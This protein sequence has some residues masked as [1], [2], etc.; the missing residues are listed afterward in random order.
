MHNYQPGS[1]PGIGHDN[2]PGNTTV[3]SALAGIVGG[4]PGPGFV[5]MPPAPPPYVPRTYADYN[6]YDSGLGNLFQSGNPY[7]GAG[8]YSGLGSAFPGAGYPPPTGSL[9]GY[10]N[11][12]T[13]STISMPP[14]FVPVSAALSNTSGSVSTS[15]NTNT[16]VNE[17]TNS[18]ATVSVTS[19]SSLSENGATF[20]SSTTDEVKVTYSSSTPQTPT[21]AA[22]IESILAQV[23]VIIFKLTQ[24]FGIGN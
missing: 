12:Q 11:P 9:A 3:A 10:S 1:F 18:S 14:P 4:G 21:I 20:P 2:L 15:M 5:M 7:S 13:Y 23:R 17:N 24:L 22:V 16:N 19:G 6:P 8:A